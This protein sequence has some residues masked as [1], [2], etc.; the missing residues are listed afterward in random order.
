MATLKR[1]KERRPDQSTLFDAGGQTEAAA[2]RSAQVRKDNS[3]PSNADGAAKPT[4]SASPPPPLRLKRPVYVKPTAASVI[5]IEPD[6]AALADAGR[7]CHAAY[8]SKTLLAAEVAGDAIDMPETILIRFD[9]E[10]EPHP[11][12]ECWLLTVNLFDIVMSKCI[13][14]ESAHARGELPD[15]EYQTIRSRFANAASLFDRLPKTHDIA[16]GYREPV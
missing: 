15:A 6:L 16:D 7:L 1:P 5:A 10:E 3:V 13:E 2:D 11:P 12:R 8:I 4:P 14:A 9:A